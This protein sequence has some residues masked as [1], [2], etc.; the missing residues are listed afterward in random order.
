M[1]TKSRWDELNRQSRRSLSL[2]EFARYIGGDPQKIRNLMKTG[3]TCRDAMVDFN[4]RLVVSIARKYTPSNCDVPFA[5]RA[6]LYCRSQLCSAVCAHPLPPAE[7]Q[8][9]L[10]RL[11]SALL[12]HILRSRQTGLRR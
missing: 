3:K 2:F 12:W 5:V 1:Q 7:Q 8:P 6:R 10:Y 11:C 9:G 4:V